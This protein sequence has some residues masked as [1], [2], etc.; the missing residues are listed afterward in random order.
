MS[1]YLCKLYVLDLFPLTEYLATFHNEATRKSPPHC[2]THP[3]FIEMYPPGL[4]TASVFAGVS[5][6]TPPRN[7][8][9]KYKN[10]MNVD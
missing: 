10:T 9:L 8:P 5:L 6:E 1:R 7:T 2:A 4:Q 3:S